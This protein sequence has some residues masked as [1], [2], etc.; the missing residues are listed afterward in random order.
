MFI[1][2]DEFG[3]VGQLAGIFTAPVAF[4]PSNWIHSD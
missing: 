2:E 4:T 1:A 3:L